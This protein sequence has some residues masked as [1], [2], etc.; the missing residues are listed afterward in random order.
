MLRLIILGQVPGTNIELTFTQISVLLLAFYTVLFI[1]H[2]LRKTDA[3][4]SEKT[5]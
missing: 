2:I 3:N 1:L 5:A 4:Q